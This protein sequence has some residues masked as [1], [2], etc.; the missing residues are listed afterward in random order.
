MA[1]YTPAKFLPISLTIT[2]TNANWANDGSAYA[3]FPWRFNAILSITAQAHDDP[4]TSPSFFYDGTNVTVGDWIFTSGD[5]FLMQIRSISSQSF[6]SVHCVIEDVEQ[7]NIYNDATQSQNAASPNGTGY[8]FSVDGD[9]YPVISPVPGTLATSIPAQFYANVLTRFYKDKFV[10]DYRV[11]QVAHGFTAGKIIYLQSSGVYALA[12]ANAAGTANPIGIVT[13]VSVGPDDFRYRPIGP[14]VNATMPAGNPGDFVYLSGTTSGAL[15]TTA[16]A[17]NIRPMFVRIDGTHGA[18]IGVEGF[19]PQ[20]FQGPTGVQGVQ[21]TPGVQGS[22]GSNG[23]QGVQGTNGTIGSNGTQGAPGVQGP[24]TSFSGVYNSGTT[25]SQGN[26]VFFNGSSY[27]SLINGNTGNQPDT[28]P[29]DWALF[30]QEG[31]QG[32][33]GTN[34]SNGV[35]GTTGSN[36]AAGTQGTTGS[37]GTNGTQGATGSNGTNGAQ[38]ATGSNG[39]NG[40]QGATGSN[41]TN[42]TQ[43]TTGANGTQGTSGVQGVQGATGTQ[44]ASQAQIFS[45]GVQLD[46]SGNPLASG[47]LVNLP[48]GWSSFA[49]ANSATSF[50]VGVQHTVGA[51]PKWI[52]LAGFHSSAS[53]PLAANNYQL[54]GTSNAGAPVGYDNAN[55]GS[56]FYCTVTGNA[57]GSADASTT[58]NVYVFF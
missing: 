50:N 34:G 43:G 36:G 3:G 22:N 25:Y 15:T 21:G 52:T 40:A 16:P 47:A 38:G 44:A 37:N 10:G 18:Y 13:D 31:N 32:P 4:N 29:S 35:Q 23:V 17:Q 55:A 5:G 51:P 33:Q 1:G 53:S 6:N 48:S 54:R 27:V 28:N 39:T 58:V 42:G 11:H 24:P 46:S 56:V 19:G 26:I 20:G 14:V 45:F 30:A 7:A 49:V 12:N 57:A 41:G 2:G 9:G 8:L